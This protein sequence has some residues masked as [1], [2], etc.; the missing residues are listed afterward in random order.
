MLGGVD[1]GMGWVGVAVMERW[2]CGCVLKEGR[3]ATSFK[4]RVFAIVAELY[5]ERKSEKNWRVWLL[6]GG[7]DDAIIVASRSELWTRV[8]AGNRQRAGDFDASGLSGGAK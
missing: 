2:V 1:V 7:R 8:A 6:S 5:C 3:N 4:T